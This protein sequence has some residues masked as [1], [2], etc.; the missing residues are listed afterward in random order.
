VEPLSSRTGGRRC[1]TAGGCRSA[2]PHRG[3]GACV[4]DFDGDVD[5]LADL[6]FS[7]SDLEIGEGE[8]AVAESVAEG[9]ERRTGLVPVAF[10]LLAGVLVRLW[11]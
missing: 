7:L 11:A 3:D 2:R 4:F 9:V 6:V 10:A 1:R 8:G 5:G